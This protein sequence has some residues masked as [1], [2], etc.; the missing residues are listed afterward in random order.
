MNAFQPALKGPGDLF[1][2]KFDPAGSRIVYST[3]L[4]GSGSNGTALYGGASVVADA[5]G[6]AYLSGTTDSVDFPLRNPYQSTRR[7]HIRRIC[8]QTQCDR[9]GTA[10]F[11][12]L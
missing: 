6:N 9:I 1:M 8:N 4:G 12:L 3:Y 10:P 5:S 11:D 2:T 7:G